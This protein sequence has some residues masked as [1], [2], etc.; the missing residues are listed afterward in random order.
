M[1]K[2]INL[3]DVKIGPHRND[4]ACIDC[5]HSH[6]Y[7][8]CYGPTIAQNE[9]TKKSFERIKIMSNYTPAEFLANESEVLKKHLTDDLYEKKDDDFKSTTTLEQFISKYTQADILKI[10]NDHIQHYKKIVQHG[11]SLQPENIILI[12]YCKVL[13]KETYNTT[14]TSMHYFH[15]TACEAKPGMLKEEGK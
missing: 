14:L 2:I 5:K 13:Y 8:G 4:F 10:A 6:W 9:L 1:N 3:L 12:C 15:M 7:T 11:P